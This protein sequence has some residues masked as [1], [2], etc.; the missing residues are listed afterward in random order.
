MCYDQ[1]VYPKS[2]RLV[3]HLLKVNQCN[4]PY[5]QTKEGKQLG[6]F[7]WM[8]KKHLLIFHISSC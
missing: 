5:Q 3:K 7:Q 1:E 4:S 8:Q 2:A 6:P